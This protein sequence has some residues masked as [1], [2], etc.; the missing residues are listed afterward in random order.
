MNATGEIRTDETVGGL[1]P[2]G[3]VYLAEGA[4]VLKARQVGLVPGAEVPLMVVSLPAALRGHAR[5]QVAE[6]QMRDALAGGRDIVEIRPFHIPG[7]EQDW[8]RVLVADRA[9]VAR[10]RK[11]AGPHCRAVLPD[12]LALPV[13]AGVWTLACAGE[14]VLARLGPEDG[15]SASLPVAARLLRDA[16]ARGPAPRAIYAPGSL[17]PELETVFEGYDIAFLREAAPEALKAL[18]LDPPRVLAHGEAGFDLRRDPRAARAALKAAVLPWRWPLLVGA[19]AAGLWAGAQMLAMT[20][21]EEQT[22]QYRKATL[23]MV[24][25]DFVPSGPVLDIR[26]QVGRALAEARVAATGAGQ[27]ASPL[28]LIGLSADVMT[29][30]GAVPDY[31]DYSAEE[32][33]RALVRVEN[34][35]A[36]DDLAAAL[37]EAGLRVTVVE[38]RVSEANDGV[39]TELRIAGPSGEEGEGG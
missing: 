12:Y 20:G 4:P 14:T 30:Q 28:D 5:E 26:S 6:R 19:V 18:K 8:T 3:F 23:E 29:A 25:A 9:A 31:M 35:A 1:F 21:L 24:R 22:A 16:L 32:G 17:R 10:W 36:A 13:S 11:M 39:R 27:E 15:F 34:F 2:D 37:G 33:L 38:S 7:K